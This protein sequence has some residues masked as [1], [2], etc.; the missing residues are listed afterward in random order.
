MKRNYSLFRIAFVFVTA[1]ALLRAPTTF[2]QQ[3]RIC[4]G[5]LG[6]TYNG[7]SQSVRDP[8]IR[9]PAQLNIVSQTTDGSFQGSIMVFGNTYAVTGKVDV[10][11]IVKFTSRTGLTG[12]GKWQDLTRGG[13]LLLATYKLSSGDQG[14]IYFLRKFTDPPSPDMPP[15]IA[16]HWGGTFES[17]LSLMRGTAEWDVQQDLTETGAPGTGFMGQERIMATPAILL[18][19]FAGTIDGQG[20]F[21]RIGVSERGFVIEGGKFE[22]GQLTGHSCLDFVDGAKDDVVFVITHFPE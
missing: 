3:V 8:N 16:G 11:G 19:H 15:D 20:N 17:D 5:P 12:T 6:C 1:C 10:N 18:Y 7:F 4:D 14:K 2:G 21:V 9:G 13:A 22:A